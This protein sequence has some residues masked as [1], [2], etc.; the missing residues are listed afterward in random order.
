VVAGR[1]QTRVLVAHE[2]APVRRLLSFVLRAD[3]CQVLEAGGT[4]DVLRHLFERGAEVDL[5]VAHGRGPIAKGFEILVAL[6][7]AGRALPVVIVRE[8]VDLDELRRTVGSV[9]AM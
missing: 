5:V 1:G 4:G 2:L 9:A 8:P 6:R 7:H 3:G